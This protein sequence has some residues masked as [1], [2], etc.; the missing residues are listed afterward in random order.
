MSVKRSRAPST[1]SNSAAEGAVLER[2]RDRRA[3]PE[4]VGAGRRHRAVRGQFGPGADRA[5][6]RPQR[7]LHPHRHPAAQ[8]FDD[9]HDAR[10]PVAAPRHEVDHPDLAVLGL[11]L[12]L[13]D[14]AARPVAAG[15]ETPLPAR[16]EQPA[17]V[18]LVAQERRQAGG[19]IE[20][21][22]AEPVDRAVAPDQRR[23]PHVTDQRIVLE[24][25]QASNLAFARSNSSA[26]NAPLSLRS[27]SFR[28][29]SAG[30]AVPACSFT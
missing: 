1:S 7:Q 2:Q 27:A 9:A 29:S 26:D 28:S 15:P 14:Q 25:H 19:R 6:V 11:E 21:G 4:A 22:Q 24:Q 5:V 18:L 10:R 3:E 8:A 23:R 30:L 13:E 20:A 12:G 17:P 16:R